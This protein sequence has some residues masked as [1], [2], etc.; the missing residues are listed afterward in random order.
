M[1]DDDDHRS[2]DMTGDDNDGD[3]RDNDGSDSPDTL[4]Q[5][6]RIVDVTVDDPDWEDEDPLPGLGTTTH[7]RRNPHLPVN[8]RC[9]QRRCVVA[10]PNVR[11]TAVR[12][13]KE[14]MKRLDALA[15]DLDAWEVEREERVHE[16]VEKHSMKPK[17]VRR[18]MLTLSTYG[19]RCKPSSALW[20]T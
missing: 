10:G 14:G 3:P 19:V 5:K 2:D 6:H 16:L 9:K 18:C 12:R 7:R 13:R 11:A 20:R 8:P 17:E 4:P 15:A 1:A